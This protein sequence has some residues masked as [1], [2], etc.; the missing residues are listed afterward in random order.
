MSK[1]LHERLAEIQQKLKVE[2]SQFNKFG[3]YNF[4]STE[5][6]LEG[7]KPL[8]GGLVLTLD[9]EMKVLY[10]AFSER[11]YKVTTASISDGKDTI[12]VRSETRED[13][14]QKGLTQSQLSGAISSYGAKMALRGLFLLDDT[15][16]DDA[17][18]THGKEDKPAPTK[19][20]EAK[21]EAKSEPA[22]ESFKR[23][24]KA[25]PEAPKG[26]EEDDY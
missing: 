23:K 21:S 11:Y 10:G 20:V 8:L 3:G 13:E 19:P 7:V 6:I 5:D 17:T 26:S 2:K 4:R 22:P 9:E 16:D 12:S 14:S 1:S 18:N 15:K 24:P 25:K